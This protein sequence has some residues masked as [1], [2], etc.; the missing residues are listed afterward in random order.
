MM[1]WSRLRLSTGARI[2]WLLFGLVLGLPTL[3]NGIATNST[4]DVCFGIGMCLV[5][6]RGFLRPVMFGKALRMEQDPQTAQVS[7]G[8]PML[9][10]GLSMVIFIALTAGIVIKYVLKG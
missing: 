9:H 10:G 7:I 5:G 2:M 6:V 1:D 4:A 3:S 8:S